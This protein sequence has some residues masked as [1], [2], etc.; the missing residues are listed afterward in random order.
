MNTTPPSSEGKSRLQL[1]VEMHVLS[2]GARDRGTLMQVAGPRR[3]LWRFLLLRK[4]CVSE[5]MMLDHLEEI[6]L[7]LVLRL[8][9]SHSVSDHLPLLERRLSNI[10][11][12]PGSGRKSMHKQQQRGLTLSLVCSQG[13]TCSRRR[14]QWENVLPIAVFVRVCP[15]LHF[16]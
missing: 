16:T 11:H 15:A 12:L 5:K 8:I 3:G 10:R 6:L 13:E 7:P 4:S 9:L 2:I 1:C 14:H